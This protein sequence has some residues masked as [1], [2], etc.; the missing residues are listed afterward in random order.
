[1]DEQEML[2]L[3]EAVEEADK[4]FKKIKLVYWK[5]YHELEEANDRRD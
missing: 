3:M 5:L 1:M 2:K 4:A